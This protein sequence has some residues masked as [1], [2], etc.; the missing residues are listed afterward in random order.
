MLKEKSVQCWFVGDFSLGQ[1]G[2]WILRRVGM[3]WLSHLDKVSRAT[4]MNWRS[5]VEFTPN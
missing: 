2:G 4:A 1:R 3:N 5:A